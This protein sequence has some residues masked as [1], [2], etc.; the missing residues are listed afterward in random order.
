MNQN[1]ELFWSIPV[2]ELFKRLQVTTSRL[3]ADEA[4]AAA[5]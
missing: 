2:T 4:A 3:T 5:F 1:L